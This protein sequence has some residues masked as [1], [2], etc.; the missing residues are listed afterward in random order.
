M[1]TQ[2]EKDKVVFIFSTKTDEDQM[3]LG[4]FMSVAEQLQNLDCIIAR[5]NIDQNEIPEM[6]DV[7][8]PSLAILKGFGDLTAAT[9]E[10]DWGVG[11]LKRFI[12]SKW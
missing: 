10:G 3:L 8:L 9:F 6:E 11:Q 7:P 12:A 1:I 2:K 4:L 5:L